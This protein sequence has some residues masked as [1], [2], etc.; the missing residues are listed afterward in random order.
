M[1]WKLHRLFILQI[2]G[3][4]AT[5]SSS[6]M[7]HCSYCRH[8]CEGVDV[9][10]MSTTH[11]LWYVKFYFCNHVQYGI[12]SLRGNMCM[13]G[14]TVLSRCSLHC[15]MS[16][17]HPMGP[18]MS[19]CLSVSVTFFLGTRQPP[20]PKAIV[21]APCCNNANWGHCWSTLLQQ[22]KLRPLLDHTVATMN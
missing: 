22:C 4:I 16:K 20:W 13:V 2:V 5:F 11:F 8:N 21:G 1:A 10:L 19:V 12:H 14:I 9:L 6:V 15:N 3:W 18:S 17:E 7:F